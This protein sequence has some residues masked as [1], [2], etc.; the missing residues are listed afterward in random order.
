MSVLIR[1]ANSLK[2]NYFLFF[3]DFIVLMSRLKKIRLDQVL[4]EKKLAPSRSKARALIMAGQVFVGGVR[5]DK[6][7]EMV[8]PEVNIIIKSLPRYVSRGGVKIEKALAHF[9]V[10]VRDRICVDI[11]ASTGGFTDCLLQ[12]GAK[13]VYAIDVGR[14]QLD[15]KLRNDPRV[16]VMEKTNFRHFDVRRISD[17]INIVVADVAFISLKLILPKVAELFASQKTKGRNTVIALI[18]PQ[19]EAGPKHLAK[20][21]ILKD[22]S[23]RE[24]IVEDIVTFTSSLGFVDIQTTPS[25]ITGADGNVEV[26]MR[27]V[28]RR[29][30]G[31]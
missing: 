17:P 28:F 31:E 4:V 23:V 14:G 5:M 3:L 10:D 24:K 30:R 9:S 20:G 8:G 1:P 29:R 16:V 19:F 7:G 22:E 18:K 12:H 13:K 26:L 21:G 27:A 11:G 25:P 6:A 15:V 2:S